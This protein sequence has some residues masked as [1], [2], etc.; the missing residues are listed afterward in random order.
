MSPD[1]DTFSGSD[2]A[3][4][5]GVGAPRVAPSDSETRTYT[6]KRIGAFLPLRALRALRVASPIRSPCSEVPRPRPPNGWSSSVRPSAAARWR[7]TRSA[8]LPGPNRYTPC[9]RYIYI[10]I[11]SP[12][13]Y[14][15]IHIIY[16]YID[17]HI[18]DIIYIYIYT[19][20][21]I[22]IVVTCLEELP[23]I[24]NMPGKSSKG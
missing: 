7:G 12:S 15:Y 10:Y 19:L 24:P 23:K 16:I 21:Y 17:I 5:G 20:I 6:V 9:H 3:S 18:I 13:P 14:I 4:T 1:T 22:V 11:S 2:F 8:I